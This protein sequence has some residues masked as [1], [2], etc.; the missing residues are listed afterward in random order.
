MG[1]TQRAATPSKYDGP[2][3]ASLFPDR[4]KHLE[5]LEKL[6]AE[7]KVPASTLKGNDGNKSTPFMKL[8]KYLHL[9]RIKR[10][11]EKKGFSLFGK[12]KTAGTNP[13]VELA[14]IKKVA[15]GPANIKYD[16]RVYVW[17]LFVDKNDEDIEAV[18]AKSAMTGVWVLK[19]W[20]V[21]RALDSIALTL[22]IMNYNN[23]TQ[24]PGERLH[25]F[26][27]EKDSPVVLAMGQK[28]SLAIPS[29]STLY[30]IRGSDL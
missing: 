17:V 13:I 12:L 21:G 24:N 9:Q 16:E 6:I 26:K 20:T 11:E 29:G 1:R 19:N 15:K 14:K 2:T 8:T 27:G 30:L 18:A 7:K 25:L 5:A 10:L 23:S 22:N 3:A 4:S 28:V